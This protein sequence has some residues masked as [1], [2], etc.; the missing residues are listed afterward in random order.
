MKFKK[1]DKRYR[2]HGLFDYVIQCNYNEY[3]LLTKYM[4]ANEWN[5]GD[6]DL[7]SCILPTIQRNYRRYGYDF[8]NCKLYVSDRDATLLQLVFA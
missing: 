3:G 2:M 5:G 6:V 8:L 1:L 4:L 7:L